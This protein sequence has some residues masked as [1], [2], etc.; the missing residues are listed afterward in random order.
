VYS[1]LLL[2]ENNMSSHRKLSLPKLNACR[3]ELHLFARISLILYNFKTFKVTWNLTPMLRYI[4][5]EC[6]SLYS[7][8]SSK[9]FKMI[10]PYKA[11]MNTKWPLQGGRGTWTVQ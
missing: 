11:G 9:K 2:K 3:M 7:Q 5:Q 4:V 8:H 1:S 6:I 10:K